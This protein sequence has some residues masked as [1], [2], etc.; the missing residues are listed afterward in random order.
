M[1]AASAH[2]VPQNGTIHVN[3]VSAGFI[4]GGGGGEKNLLFACRVCPITV[5]GIGIGMIGFSGGEMDG[6]VYSWL[7]FQN[8][9][10]AICAPSANDASLAHTT[11][12]S[13]A[14]CP[15]QVPKPQSLPATT[16]S[17]PTKWA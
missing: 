17:R 13:T 1:A 2:A 7:H 14:A 4:V 16:F 8:S 3:A 10:E 9:R 11:S 15:T 12:G 5:G 6:V